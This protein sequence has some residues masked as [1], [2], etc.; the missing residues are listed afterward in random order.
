MEQ[1]S[2]IFQEI[3][4]VVKTLRLNDDNDNQEIQEEEENYYDV[5]EE[6]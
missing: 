1:I 4:S 3:D 2:D 5:K 6:L